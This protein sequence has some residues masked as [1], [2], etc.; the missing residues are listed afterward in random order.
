MLQIYLKSALFFQFK[1]R[2]VNILQ[3]SRPFVFTEYVGSVPL[4]TKLP[5]PN[6]LCYAAGWG[7]LKEVCTNFNIFT[8][9]P[10][11]ICQYSSDGIIILWILFILS[12]NGSIASDDLMYV[13]LPLLNSGTCLSLL[14]NLPQGTICAGYAAGGKDAC[15]VIVKY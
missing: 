1:L 5:S 8:S 13:T 14:G 10:P 9:L 11:T 7:Y 2:D 3:I 6:T 4:A 12:K 15:Q